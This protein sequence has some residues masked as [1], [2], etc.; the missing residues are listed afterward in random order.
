VHLRPELPGGAADL[1]GLRSRGV[2]AARDTLL[3]AGVSGET[4][5]FDLWKDGN[6]IS[7]EGRVKSR[8]VTVIKNGKTVLA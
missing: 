5:S 3:G 1:C 2:Q 4:V 8:N 7:L 6:V